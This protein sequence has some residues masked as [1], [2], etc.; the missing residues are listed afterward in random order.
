MVG[1]ILSLVTPMIRG[2]ISSA[3]PHEVGKFDL[4]S[5]SL[6]GTTYVLCYHVYRNASAL[7]SIKFHSEG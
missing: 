2:A 6:L 4:W 3:I 7:S 1:A 5:L